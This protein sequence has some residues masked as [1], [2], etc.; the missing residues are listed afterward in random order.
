MPLI[1]KRSPNLRILPTS[2]WL[3]RSVGT[4]RRTNA[5]DMAKSSMKVV[6]RES[7][8]SSTAST[9]K[10]STALFLLSFDRAL[11]LALALPFARG[12]MGDFASV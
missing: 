7:L 6:A 4:W 8:P 2:L 11:A 3:M 10:E 1:P 5:I 12:A 9:K